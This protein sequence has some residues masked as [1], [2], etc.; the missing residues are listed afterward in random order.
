M[1]DTRDYQPTI[2]GVLVELNAHH[3]A[4]T[5]TNAVVS[6]MR[7]HVSVRAAFPGIHDT[8]VIRATR[9]VMT[10][11]QSRRAEWMAQNPLSEAE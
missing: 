6:A 9:R 10:P 7:N 4:M 11:V 5:N 3:E 8:A 1:A 2:I